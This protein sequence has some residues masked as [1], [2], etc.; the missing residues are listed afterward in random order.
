MTSNSGPAV[1]RASLSPRQAKALGLLTSDTSGLHGTGSSKSRAL[2]SSLESRLQAETQNLGS[3]LFRLT[4]KTWVLP[5]G[6]TLVRQ[7]ASVPR[8]SGTA[9]TGAGSWPT[10]TTRDWKDG[11]NP[12]I[13]VPLNALL[14]RVVWLAGWP[15]PVV[16]DTRG[17][18]SPE[19]AVN[20]ERSSDLRDF[21]TLAGWPTPTANDATGSTHQYGVGKSVMVKLS[22]AAKMASANPEASG[23][24]REHLAKMQQT[25][26]ARFTASGQLLIGSDAGMESGGPLNPAHS[27]WLMGYPTVW[28]V[29]APTATRSTRTK[30]PRSSGRS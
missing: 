17:L 19:R 28:C 20:P 9:P 3:T 8:T 16:N 1:A 27:R 15:T 11:A 2:Q 25:R 21:A 26:P 14:G 13:D 22:G 4:W 6:R 18:G 5:S 12:N 7:R 29:C 24:F 30:G 10:P 23:V